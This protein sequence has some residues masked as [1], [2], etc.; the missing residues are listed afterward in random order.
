MT[1]FERHSLLPNGLLM[2]V[3]RMTMA[4]G[5]EA[6]TPFLDEDLLRY[7]INISP[8][9]R[10][11]KKIFKQGLAN[12][13]PSSILTR[14]KQG[15]KVPFETWLNGGLKDYAKDVV[16][17]YNSHSVEILGNDFIKEFFKPTKS[18][19][20][21]MT[22]NAMIGRLLIFELWKLALLNKNRK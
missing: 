15:F 11:G 6:R 12:Y 9:K 20:Q 5:I 16:F 7:V 18:Y 14:R 13:L 10:L 21:R 22:N 3:D 17:D 1:N 8:E 2:K 4:F 19:F